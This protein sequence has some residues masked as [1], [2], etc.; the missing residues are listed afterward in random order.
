MATNPK[1]LNAQIRTVRFLPQD[2]EL[3]PSNPLDLVVKDGVNLSLSA[4]FGLTEDGGRRVDATLWNALKIAAYGSG[5][6]NYDTIAGA[7]PATYSSSHEASGSPA[8]HRVDINAL[9]APL[10]IRIKNYRT[11]QWGDDIYVASGFL[12]LEMDCLSVQVKLATGTASN[13]YITVYW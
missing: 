1:V 11:E 7:A 10:L 9:S 13:Y 2:L 8:F 12:S 6:M 3:T 4:L 5:F